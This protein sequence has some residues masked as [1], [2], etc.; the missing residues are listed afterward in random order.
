MLIEK[1]VCSVLKTVAWPLA[2]QPVIP[3][4]INICLDMELSQTSSLLCSEF[5]QNSVLFQGSRW[6]TL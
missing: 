4:V 6:Y 3:V 1:Q 5:G 2:W